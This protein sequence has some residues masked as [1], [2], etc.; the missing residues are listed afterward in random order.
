M[1]VLGPG[2]APLPLSEG[3][4]DNMGRLGAIPRSGGDS[5]PDPPVV[6]RPGGTPGP[7]G[8]TPP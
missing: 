8:E 7:R 5:P 1:V 4:L 6:G 3:R 2:A